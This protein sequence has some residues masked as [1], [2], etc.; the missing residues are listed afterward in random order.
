[1]PFTLSHTLAV[2]PFRKFTGK[3]L[4]FSALLMGSM[5]P[6]FEFFLRITLYGIWGHTFLG[7]FLFDLPVAIFLCWVFHRV[8]KHQLINHLPIFLYQRFY[9]HK[10][11][12]WQGLFNRH[13]MKVIIS[14]LLGIFTHFL[15]D[16]FTHEPNYV[17]P[18][19]AN[20]LLKPLF[21]RSNFVP[22]YSFLQL[23]SSV[24]GMAGFL[25]LIYLRKK[26]LV[27]RPTTIKQV[28]HFWLAISIVMFLL[29]A[30]RYLVGVPAEKPFEQL[31]VVTIGSFLYSLT[32]VSWWYKK[33]NIH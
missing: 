6:D 16:N 3:Y 21:F 4:S 30:L 29:V 5:A 23:A 13:F 8:V 12:Y 11:I 1:M 25:L 27:E 10:N 33:Q 19:Y 9:L 15:W 2:V 18:F 28:T 26:Q 32:V 17:S 31:L 24:V 7:V 22:L 14:A 20:F